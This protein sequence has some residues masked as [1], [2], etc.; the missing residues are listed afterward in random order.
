MRGRTAWGTRGLLHR[1]AL[2]SAV[3]GLLDAAY[4]SYE[5]LTASTTLACSDSGIVDCAKV[6][7]SGYSSVMGLPVAFVG[8]AYFVVMAIL[9]APP[10]Y[11]AD[12]RRLRWLRIAGAVAGALMVIYLVW[13]EL[14][15]LDAICLWCTGVHVLTLV[16][17]VVVLLEATYAEPIDLSSE[18]RERGTR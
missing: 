18:P 1:I 6:T 9:C 13:A 3:L 4:L 5:H 11:R 15:A 16:L 8:L 12:D 17:F 2:G 14:F 10:L 7:T